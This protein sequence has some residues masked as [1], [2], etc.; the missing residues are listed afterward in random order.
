MKQWVIFDLGGVCLNVDQRAFIQR[1]EVLTGVDE[2]EVR[3]R[4]DPVLAEYV[5]RE[6]SDQEFHARVEEAFGAKYPIQEVINAVN[7]ELGGIIPHT[8]RVIDA[9]KERVPLACL[10]NTNSIHWRKLLSD[11]R[12]MTAFEPALAS[13]QLGLAKPAPAIYEKARQILNCA[14]ASCVFFDDR[15]EN[16]IAAQAVGWDA[17]LYTGP[18]TLLDALIERGVLDSEARIEL[19]GGEND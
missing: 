3:H 1:F 16:V 15:E 10:S 8:A 18:D 19:G 9:L 6:F 11:Y 17:H 5:V 4:L 2:A 13:Q 12:F 7:A 14:A